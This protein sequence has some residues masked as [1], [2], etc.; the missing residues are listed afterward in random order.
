MIEMT[1]HVNHFFD[2]WQLCNFSGI[3]ALEFSCI[4]QR[5]LKSHHG[6]CTNS[7][8]MGTTVIQLKILNVDKTAS[9]WL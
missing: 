8:K 2:F 6:S 3:E 9:K 7:K 4:Y 5:H 1:C